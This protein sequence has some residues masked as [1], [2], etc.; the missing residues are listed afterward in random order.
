MPVVWPLFRPRSRQLFP[1]SRRC[2]LLICLVNQ[3]DLAEAWDNPQI[4]VAALSPA[5]YTRCSLRAVILERIRLGDST[6]DL[7]KVRSA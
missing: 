6:R 1:V 3:I 5:T 2:R 4:F 7:L